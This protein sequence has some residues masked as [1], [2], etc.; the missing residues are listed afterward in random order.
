MALRS[1]LA[2]GLLFG[3]IVA[4]A[5]QAAPPDAAPQLPM[6][7]ANPQTKVE[8]R[9]IWSG[10]YVG[11]EMFGISGRHGHGGVGGGGIVG[12]S[13]EFENNVVVGV[14]GGAGY[15]P[16]WQPGRVSGYDYASA[17]MKVGYDMGRFMPF[18]TTGVSLA[19]PSVFSSGFAG[20][21]DSINDLFN[22]SSGL[23]AFTTVGAGV[24]YAVTDK[25]HVGVA[26][27]V[28]AGRGVMP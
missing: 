5:A 8:E 1:V 28:G 21:T 12:Y 13:H 9:S 6:L 11:T 10:L 4:A 25:L 19:G 26:V 18:V 27:T 20:T 17:T 24:D 23:R 15:T 7:A 2:L 16:A 22:S 14:Q 3:T